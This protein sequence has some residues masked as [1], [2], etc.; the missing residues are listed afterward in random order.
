MFN[1]TDSNADGKISFDDFYNVMTKKSYAW[2]DIPNAIYNICI[3]CNWYTHF[4][5]LWELP[6]ISSG[7]HQ[8]AVNIQ[9]SSWW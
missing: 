9:D 4:D 1:K 5:N 2:Y 7:V 3:G 6:R 8:R